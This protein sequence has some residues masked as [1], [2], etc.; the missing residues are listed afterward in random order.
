[1]RP[2]GFAAPTVS[3]TLSRRRIRPRNAGVITGLDICVRA[4]SCVQMKNVHSTDDG[5]MISL[6]KR[7]SSVFVPMV[8]LVVTAFAGGTG[9]AGLVSAAVATPITMV[10]AL[11]GILASVRLWKR[12]RELTTLSRE[13]QGTL[14]DRER[15]QTEV[16][17][18]LQAN[19][20]QVG[21]LISGIR[22]GLRINDTVQQQ[23]NEIDEGAGKLGS[24]V[25]ESSKS[26]EEV[27]KRV[28]TF[29]EQVE[30]Q[31]SAVV[32]TSTSLEQMIANL[33]NVSGVVNKR[34]ERVEEL[35][36]RSKEGEAQAE[37][38]DSV[39]E[40]INARVDDMM[41]VIG[42][43][44]DIAARTNL[45]SMNAAIEAAHAGQAGAG[46]AVVADE[47]RKLAGS[48]AENARGISATLQ[49]TVDE[50]S[51]AR[52]L[53]GES[54]SYFRSFRNEVQEVS[55]AFISIEQATGEIAGGSGE[56]LSSVSTLRDV[57][58]EIQ[59]AAGDIEN[60]IRGIHEKLEGMVSVSEHT[61]GNSQRID[62]VLKQNNQVLSR[63][64]STTV[65]SVYA[66]D[67]LRSSLYTHG[68]E[69]MSARV[70][71]LHY[72][73]WASRVRRMIDSRSSELEKHRVPTAEKSWVYKWLTSGPGRILQGHVEY[74][75]FLPV[76]REF[77]KVLGEV[78]VMAHQYPEDY[79]TAEQDAELEKAY[80]G[81]LSKVEEL[82]KALEALGVFLERRW[83]ELVR[84]TMRLDRAA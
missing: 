30:S 16:D 73:G 56:I 14:E 36:T 52:N 6:K 15:V 34:R 33:N 64:I 74:D 76:H 53:V 59:G 58:G 1:M 67:A 61:D 38:T 83:T 78:I 25:K 20:E 63:L 28:N 5:R 65:E 57:T 3:S 40:H 77:H 51:E 71:A 24:S 81:L 10:G 7:R 43:I 39:I 82:L 19:D 46:F 47:I 2:Q 31:S 44:D 21:S 72:L 45:L 50:I 84:E 79:R 75:G 26:L 12:L 48:T 66:V 80:R 29:H 70:T 60:H 41:S 27:R 13:L 17:R 55:E 23:V 49:K 22:D 54:L 9:A 62:G 42:M 11:V 69:L 37:K 18:L 8:S 32:E 68:A 4:E 35:V